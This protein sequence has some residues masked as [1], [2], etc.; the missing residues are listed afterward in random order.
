[1]PF[2]TQVWVDRSSVTAALMSVTDLFDSFR[3]DLDE[4]NDRR[5]RLIKVH[6]FSLGDSTSHSS[7]VRPVVISPMYPRKLYFCYT[8]S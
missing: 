1:M 8:A 3:E 7:I 6:S 4:H 2:D 5:E